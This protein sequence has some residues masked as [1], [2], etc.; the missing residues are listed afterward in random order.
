MTKRAESGVRRHRYDFREIIFPSK[1]PSI[2]LILKIKHSLQAV[3]SD[4]A[5]SSFYTVLG[6]LFFVFF[7]HFNP[8]I[9]STL[10]Q[11]L[12]CKSVCQISRDSK[13][14]PPL[15]PQIM[16]SFLCWR[17]DAG[18]DLQYYDCVT[19]PGNKWLPEKLDAGHCFR[20]NLR[21]MRKQGN[22]QC[23]TCSLVQD[24]DS[25]IWGNTGGNLQTGLLK[26]SFRGLTPA[27]VCQ[28][29]VWCLQSAHIF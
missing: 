16:E 21:H 5:F 18:Q 8:P 1:T 7:F 4:L 17:Q 22:I 15:I 20:P 29:W 27:L 3:Q 2:Y 25:W 12:S 19:D 24:G 6:K 9:L 13:F 11:T 23:S 26:H 14:F 10:I 28:K